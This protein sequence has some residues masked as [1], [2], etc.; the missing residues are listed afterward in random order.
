M[1]KC[2][3]IACFDQALEDVALARDER[4]G[5]M[6]RDYFAWAN[7]DHD[8]SLPLD[9]QVGQ[10]PGQRLRAAANRGKWLSASVERSYWSSARK[11][12]CP[13]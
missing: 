8:G 7:H 9:E 1:D 3:P 6:L 5:R 13:T 2:P 11:P 12:A 4:L 10:L